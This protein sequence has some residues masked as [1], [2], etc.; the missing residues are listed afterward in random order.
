MTNDDG[1]FYFVAT[2][3]V[4]VL[5]VN[6]TSLGHSP[7]AWIFYGREQPF[8]CVGRVVVVPPFSILI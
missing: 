1:R 6:H 3:G 4:Q 7:L 2:V 5:V 8:S